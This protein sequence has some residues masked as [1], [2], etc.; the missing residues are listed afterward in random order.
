ML[1]SFQILLAALNYGDSS[2]AELV[3]LYLAT[4]GERYFAELYRR[5]GS[6]VYAK[7]VGMLGD[8]DEASDATQEVFVRVL[9]RVGSFRS[10]SAFGTWVYSIANNHCIDRLRK[11]QRDRRHVAEVDDLD[12][13][14]ERIVLPEAGADDWL[15]QQSVAAIEHILSEIGEIDRAVLVMMYMDELSVLEIAT[16]LGLQESATKM[17]LSRARQRARV[18][19]DR[20]AL[21]HE[22]A[23]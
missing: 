15:A 10:E 13:R 11:R 22:V 17:R 14:A 23:N 12:D 1:L 20:W 6:K 7:C 16:A 21:L 3:E 4:R 9:A 2:D 5:Y 18:V 19:Y 8:R